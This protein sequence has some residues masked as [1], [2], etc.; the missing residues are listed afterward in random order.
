MPHPEH[1]LTDTDLSTDPAA[2]AF[3][4]IPV[5]VSVEF[6]ASAGTLATPEGP[7]EHHTGDA[8]VTGG[9]G[10]RWPIGRERFDATYASKDGTPGQKGLY[11][12]REARV[13]ARRFDEPFFTHIGAGSVL[14]G[15]PGDWLVQYADG[16]KGIV[17][18]A[19]F[20]DRYRP[21]A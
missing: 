2:T 15:K 20:A 3:V 19:L 13:V 10:D 9:A 7:V 12:K 4:S 6:A 16:D 8:L 11:C 21:V 5:W 18:A 17:A 14:H 1:D